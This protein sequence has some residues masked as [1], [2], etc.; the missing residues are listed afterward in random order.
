MASSDKT[1]TV[2]LV[3]DTTEWDAALD[4]VKAALAE[5]GDTR[6]N[7]HVV[8]VPAIGVP[9]VAHGAH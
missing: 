4:R 8:G 7:A 2:K 6:I 3:L 5:L 1:I 9:P